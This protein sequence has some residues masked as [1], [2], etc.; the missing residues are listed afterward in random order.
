MGS[1]WLAVP[2]IAKFH[3]AEQVSVVSIK[4]VSVFQTHRE[5]LELLHETILSLVESA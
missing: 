1:T 3:R 4:R 2:F 5:K